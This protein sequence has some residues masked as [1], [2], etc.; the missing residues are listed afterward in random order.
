M[1]MNSLAPISITATPG[2]LWK[3]G[4]TWSAI[5]VSRRNLASHHSAA[6]FLEQREPPQAQA[7]VAVGS[8]HLAAFLAD[9]RLGRGPAERRPGEV[10]RAPVAVLHV[11]VRRHVGEGRGQE[12]AC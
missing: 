11:L 10:E 12:E 2:S 4:T 3:C 1:H 7:F 8:F 6:G 9:Q 5:A